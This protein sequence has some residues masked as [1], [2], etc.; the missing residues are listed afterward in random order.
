LSG[1]GLLT[2]EDPIGLA[3]GL[4]LYGYAGGDPVNF[5]DPL[6]L[7]KVQLYAKN[8][9]VKGVK[10]PARHA[11][12][13]TTEPD[14]TRTVF[15]GGPAKGNA[16]QGTEDRAKREGNTGSGTYGNIATTEQPYQPGSV[17]YDPNAE[18]TTVV[19]DHE[20]CDRY[21]QSFRG[22]LAAIEG[23]DIPYRPLGPN[24]N[25]V[26]YQL[27]LSAGIRPPARAGSVLLSRW[28]PGWGRSLVP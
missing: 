20:S 27:L 14:N 13:V 10:T 6:G 28:A 25:S 21:N 24:S 5:S 23:K 2:Q 26:A 12:V 1:H 3:G 15:R 16:D 18:S 4:N 9:R 7:C 11:Y 17:D 22:T 8:I 19:D